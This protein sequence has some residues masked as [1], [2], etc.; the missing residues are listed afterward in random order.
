MERDQY[1]AVECLASMPVSESLINRRARSRHHEPQTLC[2]GDPT[3][4][5]HERAGSGRGRDTGLSFLEI[6]DSWSPLTP[7]SR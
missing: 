6:K 1:A 4:C 7:R 2:R 3:E 5:R